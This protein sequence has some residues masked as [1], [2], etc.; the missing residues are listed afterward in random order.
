MVGKSI[1]YPVKFT[2]LETGEA[3]VF[4]DVTELVSSLEW[5][6]SIGRNEN[7]RLEDANGRRFLAKIEELQLIDAVFV[8]DF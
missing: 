3:Q 6:D 2:D 5:F 4:D 7:A 1:S 8:D